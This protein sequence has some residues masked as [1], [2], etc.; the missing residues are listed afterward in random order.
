MSVKSFMQ[1]Y[2]GKVAFKQILV[3][4]I[5]VI[6]TMGNLFSPLLFSFIIDNVINEQEITSSIFI[7]ITEKLG[8][9]P[10]LQQ[11]LWIPALMLLGVN[12]LVG[13]C[14]FF[15]GKLN[16]EIAQNMTEN[17]RNDLYSHIQVWP[18]S[19]LSK[20]KTGDLIQR[21]TSD[22]ETIRS[23]FSGQLA[24][25][26]YAITITVTANVILFSIDSKLALYSLFM[27]PII[28]A[29]SMYFFNK[30]QKYFVLYDDT[31]SEL[32]TIT[33]E[34][35][36]NLRVVRAFNREKYEFE[37][38]DKKNKELS[39]IDFDWIN[40]LGIQWGVGGSLSMAQVLLTILIGIFEVV[41][42]NLTIGQFSVFIS[43]EGMII[44][45]VRSLARLLANMGKMRVAVERLLEI[46]NEKTE[47]LESGKVFDIKGD[48]VFDHVGFQYDDGNLP[49]LEDISFK[50][51][52][53]ETLAIMGPTGSGKSTLV[54]LLTRL[55]DYTNGS[56]TID[57][58]E[59][60]DIQKKCLRKSIGI[61][62]QEPF[63]FSK[64][65]YD[66]IK[67]S[68][69]NAPK[70]KVYKAAKI[71][72]VHDV[73]TEFSNG[74]N[75]LVGEKGVTL[76]GGQ[77]QRIAIARTII[78]DCPILIFDDS[79]SAVDTQTD[80]A[81][82]KAIKGLSKQCTTIIIAHRISSTQ[83]AD[84]IIVLEDGKISQNGNHEQLIKQ[85][86]LYKRIYDIQTAMKED[87]VYE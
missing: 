6:Y 34:N 82:R 69:K 17:L 75:T 78:N 28:F 65:I 81:I 39:K 27:L 10:Y 68:Q 49:V 47:D 74:Y 44:Y 23:F 80:A 31:E 32:T 57:G 8:G 52:P 53:G 12:I 48:I 25:L 26:V 66:N 18:Y 51:T 56:I 5:V 16:S 87:E 86:G 84:H 3:L 35:L 29:I 61:V 50:I 83:D 55:N 71:A 42:G 36:S 54:H 30:I 24:E 19:V 45:P 60:K 76:S 33:Q 46:F 4:I 15:R 79:L 11:N 1:K 72:S 62:L 77:K 22:V 73:I 14:I 13:L 58:V 59:L 38:F 7:F 20:A 41:N 64:T 21:C 67:I 63:L 70:E 40:Q 43:Y 85:D 2:L 37:K 9:I